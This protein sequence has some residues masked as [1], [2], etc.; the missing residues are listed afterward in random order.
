MSDAR[1]PDGD[2]NKLPTDLEDEV[3][4]ALE[5][6]DATRDTV[7]AQILVRAPEHASEIRRWLQ[8]SGAMP[9]V[10]RCGFAFS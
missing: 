7:I 3:L 6:D 9:A 2:A 10:G 5:Q 4:A 8:A 1:Q